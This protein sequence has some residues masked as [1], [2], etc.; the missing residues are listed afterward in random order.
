MAVV[1]VDTNILIYAAGSAPSDRPKSVIARRILK[2]EEVVLSAQVLQEFYWVS[3]RANKLALTHQEAVAFI[4][5]WKMFPVQA[6]S[7]SI[8]EDALFLCRELRISYWDAAIIAAARH[9]N[10]E[11]LLTEDLSHGTN[12]HGVTALNPFR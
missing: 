5:T 8:V 2:T 7:M 12:Y 9:L 6:I 11:T 3:T 4:D 1:F 10:C